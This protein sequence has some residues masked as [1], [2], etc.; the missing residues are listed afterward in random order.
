LERK[1]ATPAPQNASSNHPMGLPNPPGI[2][3]E[4]AALEHS[5]YPLKQGKEISMHR[6]FIEITP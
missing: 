1:A 4:V 3:C 5:G 6:A 2:C